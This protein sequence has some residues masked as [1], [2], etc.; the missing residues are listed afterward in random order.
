[1]TISEL[2]DAV[3]QAVGR[4]EGF[5]DK[6]RMPTVAQ[7]L[8]NPGNLSH[9]KDRH[10]NAFPEVNGYVQFPDLDT[11][12][13]ALKAQCKIN[14]LKRGLTFLEFFQGKPG[15]Y[16]GFCPRNADK[17]PDLRRNEAVEYAQFV[18]RALAPDRTDLSIHS[19]IASLLEPCGG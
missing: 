16:K 1:M 13:R 18:L 9:W 12:W 4:K 17:D 14:I 2:I 10:G 8:H 5:F 15:V 19:S 3:A 7:R 11:G 6:K